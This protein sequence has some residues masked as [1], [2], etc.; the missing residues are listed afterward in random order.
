M[1]AA[2]VDSV[3][4]LNQTTIDEDFHHSFHFYLQMHSQCMGFDTLSRQRQLRLKRW[5][6]YDH[7]N[8]DVL[9]RRQLARNSD[10]DIVVHTT[11]V[12]EFRILG[13]FRKLDELAADL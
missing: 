8:I 7:N 11:H 10:F 3:H 4:L 9:L 1:L 12:R 13:K 5:L 6:N 2:E